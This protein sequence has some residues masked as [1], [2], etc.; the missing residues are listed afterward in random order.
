LSLKQLKARIANRFLGVKF[1]TFDDIKPEIDEDTLKYID[2]D[3]TTY[4][5]IHANSPRDSTDI[6]EMKPHELNL[7]CLKS[8]ATP[9][10]RVVKNRPSHFF[11]NQPRP[12]PKIDE[13]PASIE[14]V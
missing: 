13:R 12:E 5:L 4:N 8:V 3:R 6:R 10:C 9:S 14:V 7:K 1:V 11:S 2:E